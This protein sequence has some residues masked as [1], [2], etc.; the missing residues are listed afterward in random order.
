MDKEEGVLI[1]ELCTVSNTLR[2]TL[3]VCNLPL[4]CVLK[5]SEES[6]WNEQQ[7]GENDAGD[8]RRHQVCKHQHMYHNS[9]GVGTSHYSM[10]VSTHL[11]TARASARI[12]L[13]NGRQNASHYSTGVSTHLTTARD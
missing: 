10:G 11:T 2:E 3:R 13:E 5:D 9:V 4:V 1:A 6:D 7:H 12:S 8:Q